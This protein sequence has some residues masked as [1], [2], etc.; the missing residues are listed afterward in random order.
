MPDDGSPIALAPKTLPLLPEVGIPDP[1]EAVMQNRNQGNVVHIDQDGNIVGASQTAPPSTWKAPNPGDRIVVQEDGGSRL[2]DADGQSLFGFDYTGQGRFY[3]SAELLLWATSGSHLPPL[4]TTASPTDPERTRGAL[5][6]GT[7][8]IIYGNNTVFNGIDP[9]ARF[10]FGYNF[11]S[12]GLC[13]IEGNFFFLAPRSDNVAFNSNTTPVIGRPFFNVNT[14]TQDREL[15]TSPGTNP[16]DVFD[17]VGNLR[18]HMSTSLLGAEVNSR[19]LL[20]NDCCFHVT[21]ILGFR[22]LDLSDDLGITENITILRAIPGNPPNP[23]IANVGDQ[24]TVNDRF[25]THNRFYGGQVG[26]NAE[27][28]RGPWSLEAFG[29]LALGVTDQ[30]VDI[31]GSQRVASVN[32]NVQNFRGGL[33]ALPSNIGNHSQTRFGIVPE[34]GFK[35]GYDLTD[36]IRLFV[37]CDFLYW[38]SVLRPGDQID[39]SLNANNIPNSGALSPRAPRIVRWCRSTPQAT[40]PPV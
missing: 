13:A 12:C 38:N 26:A 8:Q 15:T 7:T 5:G 25:E 4:V 28:Q 23:P 9:G 16:G 40:G 32:G 6:S 39:Q 11:D 21:G 3:G 33:Y 27:W 37:G 30:S 34:V 2:V 18:I 10:T 20:W 17:G 1:F 22:Y 31:D 29:K 24:I 14:G 36:N 35:V 19:F